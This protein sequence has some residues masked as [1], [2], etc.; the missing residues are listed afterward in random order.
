MILD[1]LIAAV[2]L[3]ALLVGYQRGIIQPLLVEILFFGALLIILH[4]RQSFSTGLQKYLSITNSFLDVVIALVIAFAAGYIGGVVGNRLRRMP[5]LRGIDG[6]LGIFVHL[7]VAVVGLYI[8]V[9]ALVVLDKAFSPIVKA[10]TLNAKQVDQVRTTMGANPITGGLIDARDMKK[11]QA[12]SN[13]PTGARV[14]TTPQVRQ[15]ESFYFDFL[16]PQL[17]TS[18]LAP[19][20]LTI[21]VHTPLIGHVGPTDLPKAT[22]SPAPSPTPT[23][24]H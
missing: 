18:R 9:S 14:E 10:T 2:L 20:V 4:D 23:P 1:V 6:I 15:L 13:K 24:K 21:G 3:L 16:Q 17:V 19:Y 22:V 5:G 7:A 11:L 12:D 8:G